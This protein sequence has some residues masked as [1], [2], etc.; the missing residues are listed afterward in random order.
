MS[1]TYYGQE[2]DVHFEPSRCVHAAECIRGLGNVFDVNK[3][4]W[5]QPDNAGARQVKDIVERCPSG[6]LTYTLKDGES[7]SHSE[8]KVIH[9]DDG[10]LYVYGDFKIVQEDGSM[11]QLNRA[12]LNKDSDDGL[13]YTNSIGD[14]LEKRKLYQMIQPR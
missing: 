8:T 12:I 5:I 7:E 3:R 14:N 2:I 11:M 13:F 6:A 10:E 9:G 4:P 1:K